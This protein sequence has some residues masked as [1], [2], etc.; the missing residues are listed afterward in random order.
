[1]S[2]EASTKSWDAPREGGESEFVEV[3]R[4]RARDTHSD[5]IIIL[6]DLYST[7]HHWTGQKYPGL[8]FY[9]RC[10]EESDG[11]ACCKDLGKATPHN[12]VM[13]L[14]LA[15]RKGDDGDWT[16]VGSA[17]IW[18]FNEIVRTKKIHVII[19]DYCDG[20]PA[21]LKKQ[22]LL[23]TCADAKFQKDVVVMAAP[24]VD[25]K[26]TAEMK[27]DV[28]AKKAAFKQE[29]SINPEAILKSLDRLHGV[30]EEKQGGGNDSDIDV[31]AD[32]GEVDID[33]ELDSIDDDLEGDDVDF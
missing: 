10:L 3:E 31:E 20:D 22:P 32:D 29:I 23:I 26:I 30:P 4:F 15:E 18:G 17:K 6:S 2:K 7:P 16:P 12:S 1:M 27:E 11:G 13:I 24:K 33:A 5:I 9:L 8:K 28:K 25:V 14:H 21:K 19:R